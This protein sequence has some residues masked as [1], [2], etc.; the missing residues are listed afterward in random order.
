MS[1]DL[2]PQDSVYFAPHAQRLPLGLLFAIA[3]AGTFAYVSASRPALDAVRKFGTLIALLSV[4]T[5]K[6]APT[7]VQGS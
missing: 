5:G 3:V 1:D 7:D 2:H 4:Y 6:A